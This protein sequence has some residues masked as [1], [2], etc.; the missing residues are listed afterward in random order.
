M[1]RVYFS[2]L[3]VRTFKCTLRGFSGRYKALQHTNG[4]FH[5]YLIERSVLITE[6][7]FEY[8]NWVKSPRHVLDVSSFC[9]APCSIASFLDIMLAVTT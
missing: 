3:R 1:E 7:H 4:I 8:A 6:G 9:L 5:L 2:D